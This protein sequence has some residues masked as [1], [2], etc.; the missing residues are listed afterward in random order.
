V[1]LCT[2]PSGGFLVFASREGVSA[3]RN[4]GCACH[5]RLRVA[6]P[7][8]CCRFVVLPLSASA[9]AASSTRRR[10]VW[11]AAR[12]RRSVRLSC[13]ALYHAWGLADPRRQPGTARLDPI[14]AVLAQREIRALRPP[15][16]ADLGVPYAHLRPVE[17]THWLVGQG[18]A[19]DHSPSIGMRTPRSAAQPPRGRPR[20]RAR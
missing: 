10:V 2:R 20:W 4:A 13:R 9:P 19:R 11:Q 12:S 15:T 5:A 18:A 3:R 1:W 17:T 16:V 7:R 6:A 8:F 14:R